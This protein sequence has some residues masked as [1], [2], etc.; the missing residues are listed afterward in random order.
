M[1]IQ[2]VDN[3][4][5]RQEEIKKVLPA[6]PFTESIVFP[7]LWRMMLQPLLQALIAEIEVYRA[8]P[9]RG[10]FDIEAFNP[11]NNKTCFMGLG[12]KANDHWTDAELRAYRHAVGTFHHKVWGSEVTLLEI[13]GGDHFEK[14]PKMVQDVFSYAYGKR[15]TLPKVEFYIMPL[16]ITPDTGTMIYNEDQIAEMRYFQL[17]QENE[18]RRSYGLPAQ[19]YLAE[20]IEEFRRDGKWDDKKNC[21]K[22]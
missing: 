20:E 16:I 13:W 3:D 9:K 1:I 18:L 6:M 14:Y 15:K 4:P 22:S 12:F 7:A 10:K 8:Y 5:K 17:A 11:R 19:D 21:L 2:F